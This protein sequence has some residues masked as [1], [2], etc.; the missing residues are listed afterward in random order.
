MHKTTTPH[1]LYNQNHNDKSCKKIN[2][3]KYS[4]ETIKLKA[5]IKGLGE[6]T[7]MK[8]KKEKTESKRKKL[9]KITKIRKELRTEKISK[10]L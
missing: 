10:Y 9:E 4:K 3:I 1:I 5:Q 6:N 2:K 7:S 8:D